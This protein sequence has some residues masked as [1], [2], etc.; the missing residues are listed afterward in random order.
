MDVVG[1][2]ASKNDPQ[3]FDFQLSTTFGR[4]VKVVRTSE[5]TFWTS[6][7]AFSTS[8]SIVFDVE[9]DEFDVEND[10]FGIEDVVVEANAISHVKNTVF[11]D[12]R[13][14]VTPVG[15]NAQLTDKSLVTS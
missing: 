11:D 5:R 8:K 6:E 13:G 10:V 4:G 15:K 2:C 1:R 9:N 7:T 12:P 14:A 3:R